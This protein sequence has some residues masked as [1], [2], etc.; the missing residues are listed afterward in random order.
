LNE[1]FCR[2]SFILLSAISKLTNQQVRSVVALRSR[3]IHHVPVIAHQ[4]PLLEQ[5]CVRA[6]VAELPAQTVA[7][8][9]HLTAG[10]HVGIV[11]GTATLTGEL[12]ARHIHNWCGF[13]CSL[14]EMGEEKL[15]SFC[16]ECIVVVVDDL[17]RFVG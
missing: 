11:A 4:H 12:G 13:V 5:R 16:F 15:L 10:V 2:E 3:T 8:V 9:V 17:Y 14:Q 7:H 1:S 6:G